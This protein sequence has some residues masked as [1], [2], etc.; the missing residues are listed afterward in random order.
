MA[1]KDPNERLI[2]EEV[3]IRTADGTADGFLYRAADGSRRPGVIHLTDIGGIRASQR[4]MARRLAAAGFTVLM[5][6]ALKEASQADS[7]VEI[8]RRPDPVL[9]GLQVRLG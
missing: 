4:G 2:E 8:D 3:E 5:D 6:V 1:V 7:G 9:N